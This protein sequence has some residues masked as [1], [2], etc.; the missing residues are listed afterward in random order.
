MRVTV[1]VQ[2]RAA[3]TTLGAINKAVEETELRAARFGVGYLPWL[4]DLSIYHDYLPT[5]PDMKVPIQG[6]PAGLVIPRAQPI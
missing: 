2:V 4:S 1:A 6:M 3:R 5:I